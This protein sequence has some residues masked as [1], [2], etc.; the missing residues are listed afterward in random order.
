MMTPG[1]IDA[2]IVAERITLS[3]RGSGSRRINFPETPLR[4]ETLSG[5]ALFVKGFLLISPTGGGIPAD[6]PSKAAGG[7]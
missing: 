1:V 6:F 5:L 2:S 3:M 4:G 7:S